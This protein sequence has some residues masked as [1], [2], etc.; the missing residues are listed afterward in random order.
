M[1]L[2]NNKLNNVKYMKFV[3]TKPV[4]LATKPWWKQEPFIVFLQSKA[5]NISIVT[6]YIITIL[7]SQRISHVSLAK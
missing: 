2:M 7:N 5:L 3:L 6:S 1:R 4:G